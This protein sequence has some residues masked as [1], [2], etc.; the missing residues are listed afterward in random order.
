MIVLVNVVLR[1]TCC[2]ESPTTVLLGTTLTRTITLHELRI[3]LGSNHLLC[4]SR[5][6]S[7]SPREPSSVTLSFV[8]APNKYFFNLHLLTFLLQFLSDQLSDTKT[9][10]PFALNG[11]GS[12]AHS[13]SPHGLL[14]LLNTSF[15][16]AHQ[17]M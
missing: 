1:R 4:Y 6:I 14:L 2:C 8:C 5:T 12:I 13:A 17:H 16:K 15:F 3:L 10:R 7:T 9:I 11:H